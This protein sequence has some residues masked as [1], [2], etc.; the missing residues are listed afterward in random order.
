MKSRYLQDVIARIFD[1]NNSNVIR[2]NRLLPAKVD[3]TALTSN[4]SVTSIS[5]Q[6]TALFCPT[7]EMDGVE[8][9]ISA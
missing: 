9:E 6:T 5:L 7:W 8:T 3:V 1:R 4:P 2:A